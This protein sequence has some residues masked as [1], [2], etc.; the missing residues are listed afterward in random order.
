[1]RRILAALVQI[2]DAYPHGRSD[3][4]KRSVGK[5]S[6]KANGIVRPER[7]AIG[8]RIK[9]NPALRHRHPVH[10][11]PGSLADDHLC[12]C[13]RPRHSLRKALFLGSL[14]LLVMEI[15]PGIIQRGADV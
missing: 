11:Q 15:A 6:L 14:C 7:S 4:R 3:K 9:T 8:I 5:R 10:I 12:G 2:L 1:M 13:R